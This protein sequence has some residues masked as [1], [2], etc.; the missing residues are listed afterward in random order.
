MSFRNAGKLPTALKQAHLVKIVKEDR[1]SIEFDDALVRGESPAMKII[2]RGSGGGRSYYG[3]S[4][5]S[6]AR[7]SVELN[8]GFTEGG[9][10]NEVEFIVRVFGEKSITGKAS[11]SSTRGGVL[12]DKDFTI[13]K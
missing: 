10:P 5:S 4:R 3:S 6:S 9:E 2:T 8:A 13:N 12:K 7:S 1:I 11:V